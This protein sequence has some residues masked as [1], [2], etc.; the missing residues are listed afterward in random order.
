VTKLV[1]TFTLIFACAVA[2]TAIAQ[3]QDKPSPAPA[4]KPAVAPSVPVRIQVVIS[5]FQGDKK[6]S[7]LP[8]VLTVNSTDASDRPGHA[9]MRMGTKVPIPATTFAPGP[10]GGAANNSLV[11]YSYQDV[12]TNI[13][14]FVHPMDD[15]RFRV[16]LTID[17]S[18]VY[19]EEKESAPI[20]AP[21]IRSFR[22]GDSMILKDGGTGQFTTAS[23]K[24]SGEIVKVDVTLTVVK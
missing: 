23:D 15:G 17:D 20:K 5:R 13:D 6:I 1:P 3:P 19:P 7:S 14:C 12:G 10:P 24:V 21:S 22:A 18:S 2:S 9:T 8:Y 4:V 11:S 16:D